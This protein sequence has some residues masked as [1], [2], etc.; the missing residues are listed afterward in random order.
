[1]K[2]D[3]LL[4]RLRWHATNAY[5]RHWQLRYR[6]SG[7][8]RP[9][10]CLLIVGSPRSGTTWL[11]EVLESI[12]NTIHLDEPLKPY[13]SRYA[14][15]TLGLGW[16]PSLA[17]GQDPL[18]HQRAFFQKLFTG[19]F[20]NPNIVFNPSGIDFGNIE[21]WLI[22]FVR[23]NMLLP[24]VVDNFPVKKPIYIIR[25]PYSVIASQMKHPGWASVQWKDGFQR[26][27]FIY[28]HIAEK[29]QHLMGPIDSKEAFLATLWCMENKFLLE[30]P[31]HNH[32]WVTVAYEHLVLSP[33]QELDRIAQEVGIQLPAHI[34]E[35]LKKPSYSVVENDLK[36]DPAQQ[37]A[38]WRTQLSEQQT[39]LVTDMLQRFGIRAYSLEQDAPVGL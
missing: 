25:N 2:I 17:P 14:L 28:P 13:N 20:F 38:K 19:Q 37:L 31:Y 7:A 8:H 34:L 11:A 36:N 16:Y 4:Q 18:P 21:H 33:R 1:M 22:K 15:H 30:H 27:G 10:D 32:K 39:Q 12:P 24:W 35:A 5:Y 29:Y 6:L 9:E 26:K 3:D 23:L